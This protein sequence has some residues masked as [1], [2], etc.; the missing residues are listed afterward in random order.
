MKTQIIL[1]VSGK[2]EPGL[3]KQLAV[4]TLEADG[5]WLSHKITH[6]EGYFS[7]LFKIEIEQKKLDQ[8]KSKMSEFTQIQVEYYEDPELSTD[9][10]KPVSLTIEG[11]DRTGLASEISHLLYDQD[12]KVEHFESQRYPVTGLGTEVFEAHLDI[13]L[14]EN[15]SVEQLKDELENL[16]DRLRV[17]SA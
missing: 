11:E 7:G 13:R 17:L 5:K 4:S 6:L 2:E 16:G 1:A 9:H 8:L 14:P 15:L 10:T 3:T 12:V